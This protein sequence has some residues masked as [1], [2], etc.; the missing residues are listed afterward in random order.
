M[1]SEDDD[2]QKIAT[3][4]AEEEPRNKRRFIDYP[5]GA[6]SGWR[7]WV[8]SWRLVFGSAVAL[9]LLGVAALALAV[10]FTP[11]P[12]P[13]DIALA[14]TTTFYWNDG[15]TVL[16][17]T[18]DAN[19]TSVELDAVPEVVRGAVIAAED[20]DFFDHSG[21]SPVG[22]TRAA[23]NNLRSE[24]G[25]Q[26]GSTITQQYAKNAFLTQDQTI[27]RKLRELVLAIRL[28]ATV[29]KETIL[30]DY[31]NTVFYGRNAYGIEAAAQAYFDKPASELTAAE[32]AVLA[33]L[34]QAPNALAPE[35]NP[36]GLLERWNY[37]L[38]GMV[39]EGFLTEAERAATT[40]PE[41][42][43]FVPQI[44]T[45]GT[46][47]FL[48]QAAQD[49]LLELG[50]SSDDMN[51]S[52][53]RVVTTFDRAKQDAAVAAVEQ[54]DP[55][56]T[57]EGLRIG[58]AS[59]VPQTGEVV[60]LYGGPDYQENQFN[61]ATQA[62]GQAGSTFKA[63][64]LAAGLE[65]GITLNTSY[66]GASPLTIGSYQV[67]NY[68]N[69]SYGDVSMLF[70]TVNSLNT[71]F[72]QMNQDIGADRTQQA[73]IAAGIPEDTP[74]LS[75]ELN[76]IL[77]SAS[78]TPMEQANAFATLAARG[79]R[80]EPTMIT[81]VR[82]ASGQKL[83]THKPTLQRAFAADIV[84]Q[85]TYAL[86]R[87]VTSGTG[88]A[89][90]SA[91]RPV[92]GKTGTSDNYLSAWFG[93]YAPNLSTAVMVVRTDEAGN[94]IS[95]LGEGGMSEGTGGALPAQIFGAY[96][97]QAMVDMPVE[98]FQQPATPVEPTPTTP[99]TPEESITPSEAP[100]T[101]EPTPTPTPTPTE[102]TPTPVDPT[103]T[104]IEPTPTPVDPTPVPTVPAPVAPTAP[105]TQQ[106]MQSP[107][108]Q[109]SESAAPAGE[110]SA[111]LVVFGGATALLTRRVG[112]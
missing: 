64:G 86:Q 54:F 76:N 45:A 36:E 33:A 15:T 16:G 74:G 55:S 61:N 9:G 95:L 109:L 20:R 21:F 79:E 105:V 93:G 5:R 2:T 24:G 25:T 70:S 50:Y 78:P 11:V 3:T 57:V 75:D 71:P 110:L 51:F 37:V 12:K 91:N 83:Y 56:E 29:S 8:P 53:L 14:Q 27:T 100:T 97:N 34:L 66:S 19:R 32:G 23:W 6:R 47:G 60:A 26:G 111:G 67:E 92:A 84:D 28:E 22:I 69:A 98:Y 82:R 18:G 102:P 17:Q 13:N 62:R 39:S 43:E 30:I 52:G 89:A 48:F 72:V 108:A 10:L 96:M 44:Y 80:V 63:F 85:V 1:S 112:R 4:P 35:T 88:T 77:G 101:T 99:A 90:L 103:P 73:L 104:P 68:G 46:D 59:M 40:F 41:I 58:M 87:V 49:Q 81:E 7:R 31:L 107:V 42:V 38:D 94:E 106:S 65:D